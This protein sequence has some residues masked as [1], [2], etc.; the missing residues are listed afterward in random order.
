MTDTLTS[1]SSPLH[2][3]VLHAA[4]PPATIP[5][6]TRASRARVPLDP[7]TGI[8]GKILTWYAERRFGQVPEAMLAMASN[9]KVLLTQAGH[10]L[11]L[12]RWNALDPQLRALAEMAAASAIECSWCTDFGYYLAHSAGLDLVK[13]AAVPTWR[14]SNVFTDLE[15]GVLEYAEAMTATPPTAGDDLVDALR[16]EIG[17]A[18]LVELTMMIA[19]ENLRS[20]V[21]AALG[22]ASQ[23]FSESCRVPLR[24]VQ[25]AAGDRPDTTSGPAEGRNQ[26]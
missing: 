10:E 18:A 22:L 19:V 3:T 5:A 9:R 23:G 17:D 2:P 25:P 7:P 24:A 14:T 11:S 20:R 12:A 4:V 16:E 13:I 21:N 1:P 8:L 15:R 26:R 6:A